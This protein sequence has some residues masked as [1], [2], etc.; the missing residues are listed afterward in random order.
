MRLRLYVS[1]TLALILSGP[2]LAAWAAGDAPEDATE[3]VSALATDEQTKWDEIESEMQSRISDMEKRM[4]K[5]HA[6]LE[7]RLPEVRAKLERAREQTRKAMSEAEKAMEASRRSLEATR[8]K[9]QALP[10]VPPVPLI[11][12]ADWEERFTGE[13]AEE[14]IEREFSATKDSS[15]VINT[16]FAA[17]D[18][19][20]EDRETV[21]VKAVRKAGGKTQEEA[22]ENLEAI[23]VS[24]EQRG[25]EIHVTGD[26]K[27]RRD[28]ERAQDFRRIQIEV[29][30][31]A[32]VKTDIKN[33][34]GSVK[35]K[36]LQADL[37][38]ENQ[39]GPTAVDNTKGALEIES[40][41]TDVTVSQHS[42]GGRIKASFGKLVIDG[43]SGSLDAKISYVKAIVSKAA[44]TETISIAN[45]FGPITIDLQKAAEGETATNEI[46]I[47]NKYSPIVLRLPESADAEISARTSWGKVFCDFSIEGKKTGS[48]LNATLGQGGTSIQIANEFGDIRLS[49]E[50][51]QISSGSL[52]TE[53]PFEMPSVPKVRIPEIVIPEIHIPETRIPEISIPGAPTQAEQEEPETYAAE[54][55]IPLE[56]LGKID[57]VPIK[58]DHGDVTVIGSDSGPYEV[59]AKKRIWAESEERAQE[60]ADQ[61]SVEASYSDSTLELEGRRPE[62]LPSGVRDARVDYTLTIPG[63]TALQVNADHGDFQARDIRGGVE[64]EH[65][66]GNINLEK[67]AGR[68]TCRSDHGDLKVSDVDS[69]VVEIEHDHGELVLKN[70][71]GGINCSND[72][73]DTRL[74]GVRGPVTLEFGHGNARIVASD[75][76]QGD[77]EI[78]GNHG[79]CYLVL[80]SKAGV[81]L[82]LDAESGAIRT[83][84]PIQV[85]RER[86][87]QSAK[88]ELN[89]GGTPITITVNHGDINVE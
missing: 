65:D 26:L 9:I 72:H 40:E 46:N 48:Q 70:V 41:Y 34:F 3:P 78:N 33:K 81:T 16:K 27:R 6:R 18:V 53:E 19:R 36:G 30:L 88:A 23:A 7:A 11:A 8:L 20:A 1:V 13:T 83:R 80:P 5:L 12:A 71:S 62:R 21:L 22:R 77:W 14:K 82:S 75:P 2:A 39:F 86:R 28:S 37:F 68:L 59:R 52:T 25:D 29:L 32:Y 45:Q 42:G 4:E 10:A 79:S 60:V 57:K 67:I 38:V 76:L 54:W 58:H 44:I 47:T 50:N 89:G 84:L 43:W 24:V 73:A 63:D 35:A 15:L 56:D 66:H 74:D 31:P 49:G 87:R 17:V 69:D 61:F 85:Q 64:I 55:A 51:L